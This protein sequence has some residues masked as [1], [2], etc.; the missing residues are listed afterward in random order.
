MR[1]IE[2][3]V[4]HKLSRVVLSQVAS[5]GASDCLLEMLR[6]SHSEGEEAAEQLE[7]VAIN[8]LSNLVDQAQSET[9]RNGG[10]PHLC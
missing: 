2:R 5:S 10:F 6:G 4:H 8:L 3:V 7:H 9:T 1:W